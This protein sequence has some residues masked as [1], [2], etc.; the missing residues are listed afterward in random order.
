[1]QVCQGLLN[2]Y[3]GEGDSFLDRIITGRETWCHQY[4]PESKRQSMEWQHTNSPTKERFK[5]HP[6]AGKVMSTVF[7]DRKGGILLYFLE[8]R[9]TIN[10]DYYIVTMTKLKAQISRFRLEKKTTFLLQ[11]DNT[12]PHTSLKTMGMLQ[13][14][15]GLSYH[16]Y[17]IVQIWRL[18]TSF[19]L[20]R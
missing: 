18:L 20:G 2:H 16:T 14:L 10:S 15:A 12:R 3:E 8:P 17:C 5:T 7:W 11:H 6:S 9:Q 19:C 1:M 13:S 4:E